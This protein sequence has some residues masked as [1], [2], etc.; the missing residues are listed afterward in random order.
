[1][2]WLCN[3]FSY[4]CEDYLIR[5]FNKETYSNINFEK[6]L[7]ISQ[8]EKKDNDFDIEYQKG[9]DNNGK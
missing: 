4:P 5:D 8:F 6:E 9:F 2:K 3:K 1:M 7:D